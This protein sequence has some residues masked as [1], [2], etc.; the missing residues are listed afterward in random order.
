MT[1][2]MKQKKYGILMF[3]GIAV[4]VLVPFAPCRAD[5]SYISSDTY[6]GDLADGNGDMGGSDNHYWVWVWDWAIDSNSYYAGELGAVVEAN[7]E[8]WSANVYIWAWD[9]AAKTIHHSPGVSY[10]ASSLFEESDQQN[11]DTLYVN[12]EI[13]G[14]GTS[15]AKGYVGDGEGPNDS[16]KSVCL[17]DGELSA[18]NSTTLPYSAAAIGSAVGYVFK[19]SN[20]VAVVAVGYEAEEDFNDVKNGELREYSATLWWSVDASDYEELDGLTEF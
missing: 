1:R 20:G 5:W 2:R 15:V 11:P 8:A 10:W 7:V 9:E 3:V 17:A 12:W 18:E 4:M 16:L 14:Q 6:H 13:R 19:D